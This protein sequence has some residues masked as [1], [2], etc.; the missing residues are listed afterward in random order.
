MPL[1]TGSLQIKNIQQS[2]VASG[3]TYTRNVC[4]S[5]DTLAVKIRIAK[6]ITDKATVIKASSDIKKAVTASKTSCSFKKTLI[7]PKPK[8]TVAISQPS[9]KDLAAPIITIKYP[10]VLD[11]MASSERQKRSNMADTYKNKLKEILPQFYT[12]GY[13]SKEAYNLYVSK[14]LSIIYVNNCKDMAI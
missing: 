10:E 6:E 5:N 12:K 1:A 9:T 4:S 7:K 13:I 3:K 11:A 14:E 2:I 8:P